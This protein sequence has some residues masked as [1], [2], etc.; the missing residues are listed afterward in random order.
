MSATLQAAGGDHGAAF[1]AYQRRMRDFVARNQQIAI[2]NTKR[3]I[4]QTRRQIWLQNQA[5]RTLLYLP[6]KK[7]VLDL[8]TKGVREAASAI[9]L[10]ESLG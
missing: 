1:A 5:I 6:G 3:F 10:E 7:L 9:A 2:G 4:P 8:A